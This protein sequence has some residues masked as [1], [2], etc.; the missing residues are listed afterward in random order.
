MANA[1]YILDAMTQLTQGITQSMDQMRQDNH[2]I[3]MSLDQM[4]NDYRT[5]GQSVGQLS[6]D[7]RAELTNLRHEFENRSRYSYS[8]SR[9][10][11]WVDRQNQDL[12]EAG[13]VVSQIGDRTDPNP[14]H[15]QPNTQPENQDVIRT[16]EV[17]INADSSHEHPNADSGRSVE[18]PHDHNDDHTNVSIGNPHDNADRSRERPHDNADRSHERPH[19]AERSHDRPHDHAYASNARSNTVPFSLSTMTAPVYTTTAP[20][21]NMPD[22]RFPPPH[23]FRHPLPRPHVVPPNPNGYNVLHSA[24][25]AGFTVADSR[26]TRT[27]TT[28]VSGAEPNPNVYEMRNRAGATG[29]PAADTLNSRTTNTRVPYTPDYNVNQNN[30]SL[31]PLNSTHAPNVN[32]ATLCTQSS[33]STMNTMSSGHRSTA[34]WQGHEHQHGDTIDRTTSNVSNVSNKQNVGDLHVRVK[35]FVAKEMDWLDFRDYF[36]QVAAKAGWN[37]NIKCAKMLA[38]L[39]SSLL[40][41]TADLGENYTFD[42]LIMKLDH[43]QGA[44]YAS[45]DASNQ[46]SSIRRKDLESIPIFA[47]RC[48]RLAARAYPDYSIEAKNEQALKAMIKGLPKEFR[49]RMKLQAFTQLYDAVSYA[50]NLD[51]VMKEERMYNRHVSRAIEIDDNDETDWD[52]SEQDSELEIIR[53]TQDRLNKRV[54]KFDRKFKRDFKKDADKSS[55]EATEPKSCPTCGTVSKSGRNKQNSPCFKCGQYFHWASE[56]PLNETTQSTDEK[57]LN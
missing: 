42:H 24:G 1:Q 30:T 46:L 31:R 44:E 21:F 54:S 7:F 53:K 57:P 10:N 26:Y 12:T 16:V 6:R 48:R 47:E 50:S 19:N 4:Q 37:D 5:V 20:P 8:T 13:E 36:S 52:E 2:R 11:E 51:H 23:V 35:N 38:A 28:R 9:T 3:H 25:I 27:A 45:R 55:G 41:I 32:G 22:V 29:L 14:V 18:I 56:C 17:P 15:D 49:F 43:I 33:T 34:P 39:D 40:G